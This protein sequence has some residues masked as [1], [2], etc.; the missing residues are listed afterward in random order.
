MR[1][2]LNLGYFG[3]KP[4]YG[5]WDRNMV[6][7]DPISDLSIIGSLTKKDRFLRLCYSNE[8]TCL[9]SMSWRW[10]PLFLLIYI[11]SFTLSFSFFRFFSTDNNP[12]HVIYNFPFAVDLVRV[13]LSQR[14]QET[15]VCSIGSISPYSM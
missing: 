4:L 8:A 5:H 1:F 14:I 10:D 9:M 15:I 11:F 13:R 12:N 3:G 7:K 2:Q 6:H